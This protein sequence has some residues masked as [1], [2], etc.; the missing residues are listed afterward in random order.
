MRGK[1]QLV[2]L[3][4]SHPSGHADI[5]ATVYGDWCVHHDFMQGVDGVPII[6]TA[7]EMKV[8]HVPCGLSLGQFLNDRHHAHRF[9]RWAAEH[10]ATYLDPIP[11]YSPEQ[12]KAFKAAA[13]AAGVAPDYW[14]SQEIRLTGEAAASVRLDGET[15]AVG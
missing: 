7:Y 11:G 4:T 9:A 12:V 1:R 6:L 5:M 14:T 15:Q 13:I 8:S 2:R 3:R 10:A